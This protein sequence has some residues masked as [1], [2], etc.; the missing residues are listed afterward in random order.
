MEPSSDSLPQ[1][2]SSS[3]LLQ[4]GR[5]SHR[6]RTSMHSPAPQWNSWYSHAAGVGTGDGVVLMGG[7]IARDKKAG[8]IQKNTQ[9]LKGLNCI[10]RFMIKASIQT[11][12]AVF[13]RYVD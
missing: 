8:D 6:L 5:P 7:L 10:S 12:K 3:E 2:R 11:F 9:G 4:S 1:F 13:L